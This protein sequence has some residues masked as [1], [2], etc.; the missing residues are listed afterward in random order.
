LFDS[1]LDYHLWLRWHVGEPCSDWHQSSAVHNPDFQQ[2]FPDTLVTPANKAAVGI[3][4]TPA[5]RRQIPPHAP[6]SLPD[7]EIC[8]FALNATEP[9]FQYGDNYEYWS[10]ANF[11]P[12]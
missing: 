6:P 1:Y 11:F 12:D 3:A 8:V 5:V 9:Y 4:P 7:S 10:I 2:F